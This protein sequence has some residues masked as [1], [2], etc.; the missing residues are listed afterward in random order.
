[1]SATLGADNRRESEKSVWVLTHQP[2]HFILFCKQQGVGGGIVSCF[3][4]LLLF[5]V[6]WVFWL[7]RVFIAAHRL[8]C[9]TTF[10]ESQEEKACPRST[11]E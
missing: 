9:P 7:H 5:V 2:N 3:L 8:S 1:M 6:F 10:M 4:F 11:W